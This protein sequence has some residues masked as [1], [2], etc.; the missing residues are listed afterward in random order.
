MRENTERE[1]SG[2]K[3]GDFDEERGC[4]RRGGALRRGTQM[5]LERMSF[6]R[7]QC[8]VVWRW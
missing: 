1:F 8:S 2:V 6:I 3:R 5:L 7:S 4:R